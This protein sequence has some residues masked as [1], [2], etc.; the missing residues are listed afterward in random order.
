M[1]LQMA[2]HFLWLSNIPSHYIPCHTH[3]YTVFSIHSSVD[4]H[5]GF[6]HV[7]AIGNSAALNIEMQVIFQM[8]VF[9]FSGYMLRSGIWIMW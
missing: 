2:F 7:L 3:T 4:G 5:L 9:I 6:F 8:K 1:W